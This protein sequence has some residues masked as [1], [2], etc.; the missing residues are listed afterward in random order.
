MKKIFSNFGFM[1]LKK[2]ATEK[3]ELME[4][5]HLGHTFGDADH[6]RLFSRL[7]LA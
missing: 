7:P 4:V 2:M 1:V 5:S 6:I 3:A